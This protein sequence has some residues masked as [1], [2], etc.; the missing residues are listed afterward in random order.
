MLWSERSGLP[1]ETPGGKYIGNFTPAV[2]AVQ[3]GWS[4]STPN[5]SH[6]G[7]FGYAAIRE[8]RSQ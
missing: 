4:S 6:T 3:G 7:A 1:F 8:Q 2:G 5:G